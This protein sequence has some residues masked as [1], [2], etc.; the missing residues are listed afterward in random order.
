M[1]KLDGERLKDARKTAEALLEEL[2]LGSGAENARTKPTELTWR[3]LHKLI[4]KL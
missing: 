1:V 2:E 3:G 4:L